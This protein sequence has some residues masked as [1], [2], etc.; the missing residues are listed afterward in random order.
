MT[1]QLTR[2]SPL[3]HIRANAETLR[4][5]AAPSDELGRL[6]DATV[7]VL[8][9]SGVMRLYAPE[10]YGG[11]EAHPVEFMQAAMEVGHSSPSAG[12]VTGVVGVH[13][14]EIAMM[15]PRLQEEIWGED[16]DVWTASPYAPFGVGRP[17][18]G[19]YLFTGQWPYSTGTDAS[20]WVILGGMVGDAE[21]KP[22]M[23]P[24]VRHFV[25]P[26]KDYEIVEDSWNVMGLKGT[27]SKDVKMTDVFVPD[28]RTVGAA[29]MNA[30]AYEDR[31]PGK[32]LYR[33]KFP[34]V[35]SA[36]INSG[37]QGIAE[38]ALKVFHDYVL[39][40]VSADQRVAKHDPVLMHVYSEAAA[41]VAASRT[42]LLNDMKE[43]Y[44]FVDAGG[45]LTMNERVRVRRNGVRAVRRSV[46]AID[47]L[48]KIAGSQSIHERMPN[49]RYW[50][51]LQAGMSHICN[52]D[53]P[54]Y[55]AAATLDFGGEITN[56]ML[57]A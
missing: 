50:R 37:T 22:L 45:E 11:A 30:G 47:R 34:V 32:T 24:Q 49:E 12:W 23:P 15:D 8:R 5:E 35:F 56:P 40:R 48:Y 20:D 29:E 52:V 43:L 3:E 16:H 10:Q 7:K 6:T 13:P 25:I 53:G 33:L 55:N 51:D 27:G 44:D 17:V 31:Q 18:D 9:D 2:T 54:I 41:D 19:G 21:G 26:R 46:D 39:E 38:G 42:V 57:F 28:Y 1:S 4:A 14:W 36:A